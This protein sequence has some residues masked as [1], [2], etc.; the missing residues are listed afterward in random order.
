MAR[1]LEEL[2]STRP[3]DTARPLD[4]L[5]TPQQPTGLSRFIR[6]VGAGALSMVAT[7][8]HVE[9]GLPYGLEKYIP[10]GLLVIPSL[11]EQALKLVHLPARD[12]FSRQLS[13]GVDKAQSD[14]GVGDP[15][16]TL[17]TLGQT[18][19]SMLIPTGALAKGAK[20][21][22]RG[23]VTLALP[24]TQAELG[25]GAKTFAKQFAGEAAVGTAI[26]DAV[27]GASDPAYK[28]MIRGADPED[29]ASI[30]GGAQLVDNGDGTG[31]IMVPPAPSQLAR[32]TVLTGLGAI[33]VAAGSYAGY[34]AA[35]RA[36]TG[37]LV[38]DVARRSGDSLVGVAPTPVPAPNPKP[39]VEDPTRSAVKQFATR[40]SEGDVKG[41][42]TDLATGMSDR[43]APV[44]RWAQEA[45]TP[46]WYEQFYANVTSRV[47]PQAFGSRLSDFFKTGVFPTGQTTTGPA[48]RTSPAT[49]ILAAV[50]RF[51]PDQLRVAQDA[52]IAGTRMDDLRRTRASLWGNQTFQDL[53][54]KYASA[55]TDPAVKQVVEETRQWFRDFNEYKYRRGLI[56]AK[57]WQD[58]KRVAPNYVPLRLN[59]PDSYTDF[60]VARTDLSQGVQPGEVASPF[61]L[62]SEYATRVMRAAE[63]NEA[64]SQ[65]IYALSGKGSKTAGGKPVVQRVGKV[66]QNVITV[67]NHGVDE[68]WLVNDDA[69]YSAMKFRPS[70]AVP[71]L[72]TVRYWTQ[73][74]MTGKLRPGFLPVSLAYE[75]L[76]ALMMNYKG[77]GLGPLDEALTHLSDGKFNTGGLDPS[78]MLSP[79]TG[80]VRAISADLMHAGAEALDMS[81]RFN[82]R[83]VN[84]LGW[85]NAKVLRDV[86]SSAYENSSR[87]LFEAHGGGTALM[88]NE[89]YDPEKLSRSLV[90]LSPDYAR[91]YGSFTERA[92]TNEFWTA[93]SG[94][95]E[96]MHASVRLQAFSANVPRRIEVGSIRLFGRDVPTITMRPTV[97]DKAIES[98]A[99]YMR[100]LTG[101][102][103][104]RIGDTQTGLGKFSQRAVDTVPYANI[105]IQALAQ[106]VRAFKA[107]PERYL[108][109]TA[110]LALAGGALLVNQFMGN[111][112]A[113][114]A[115]TNQWTPSQRARMWPTFND[116]GSVASV[117]MIPQEQ[118]PLWSAFVEGLLTMYGYRGDAEKD[119]W[120][121]VGLA[122]AFESFMQ[123]VVPS[124]PPF[125]NAALVAGGIQPLHV[126]GSGVASGMPGLQ[127]M[128]LREA[129]TNRITAGEENT[130]AHIASNVVRELLAGAGDMMIGS[131]NGL[132]TG[133]TQ[134]RSLTDV[135]DLTTLPLIQPDLEIGRGGA[136]LFPDAQLPL[137]IGLNDPIST[138]YV[139][140]NQSIDR[141]AARFNSSVRRE[142]YS[143]TSGQAAPNVYATQEPLDPETAFVAQQ[144]M[145]LKNRLDSGIDK[146]RSDLYR[147]LDALK[148]SQPFMTPESVRQEE[149]RIR[150]QLRALNA[151]GLEL[152]QQTEE[153]LSKQLGKPVSFNDY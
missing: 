79:I 91:K 115:Y 108:G 26:G 85:S 44:Y 7:G 21:I 99:A 9:G 74:L 106:N 139:T 117:T 120:L 14:V 60:D 10:N 128:Q 135:V 94:L 3:T 1:S 18:I 141:L 103:G 40:V 122:S 146:P 63:T 49:R 153:A 125:V 127:D 98:T 25:A 119:K 116:D 123:D 42:A 46:G 83:L 57:Q 72:S 58:G 134:G 101:D 48:L 56:T 137:R 8:P 148:L 52:L 16:G 82:G 55:I 104:Q 96:A 23:L 77:K 136:A 102:A 147:Q 31:T 131:M 110:G 81:M 36:L 68:H 50:A 93:Y 28:P 73:T 67:S 149:N 140:R 142:G 84:I 53:Q 70:V 35:R 121:S 66:G 111:P 71:I 20:P 47:T 75:K 17:D 145:L 19:G 64:R 76:G 12:M 5:M 143:G 151:D 132:V 33:A 112:N 30:N 97:S 124:A 129:Y 113:F 51:T 150:M 152:V 41:I 22:V 15:Q 114:N 80:G 69:L 88:F 130:S 29:D 27:Q 126:T 90:S 105:A 89:G 118:R 133:L 24:G 38:G 92:R 6:Q 11:V 107:A 34:R 86:M 78:I 39:M 4:E 13:A 37:E 59:A 2:Y 87:R 32:D 65:L 43:L 61:D 138:E 109:V 54:A 45:M 144:A 100:R 62:M 95:L